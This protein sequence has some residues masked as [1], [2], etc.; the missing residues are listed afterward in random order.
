MQ[1]ADSRKKHNGVQEGETKRGPA[2]AE[3]NA[4]GVTELSG[5]DKTSNAGMT[6]LEKRR[7][8]KEEAKTRSKTKGDRE[9]LK[10]GCFCYSGAMKT[11]GK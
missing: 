9:K 10:S 1:N 6:W 3:R 4:T 8:Q 7:L 2:G 5:I 11:M